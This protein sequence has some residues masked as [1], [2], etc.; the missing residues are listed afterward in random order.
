MS[1][2]WLS[3][4]SFSPRVQKFPSEALDLSEP[5]AGAQRSKTP[6][7]DTMRE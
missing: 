1:V 4:D 5:Q 7:S 3:G 2:V 6:D